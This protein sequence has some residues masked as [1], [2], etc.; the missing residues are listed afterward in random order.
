MGL[1]DDRLTKKVGSTSP[2]ATANL[3]LLQIPNGGKT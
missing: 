3:P 2:T 1:V